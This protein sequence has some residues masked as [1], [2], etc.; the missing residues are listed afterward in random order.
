MDIGTAKPSREEQARVPHHLIDL[1]PPTEAYSAARF[2][3][4]A[5]DALKAILARGGRPLLVGGTLLYYR[6]LSEGLSDL[7]QASTQVRAEIDSEATRAGWP[8][9]HRELARIDPETAGRVDPE[10]R[11]RIQRAL[12]V[13]RITGEPLSRLRGRRA[14]DSGLRFRQFLLLPDDRKRLHDRIA[15]RLNG[16]FEAGL[17]DEVRALRERFALNAEL[18]AMR[19]VG[20][21]QV[22]SYLEGEI[23][24]PAMRETA[25]YA[26]RQLAKRQITWLRSLDGELLDPFADDLEARLD[27]AFADLAQ[28]YSAAQQSSGFV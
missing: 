9:L 4:D 12:E 3:Q 15:A 10:D 16:M 11:Q 20:Y 2:A 23:D 8:A 18:P 26:T 28:S 21:R 19:A 24:E 13:Y 17:V 27:A 1:V 22:W 25:L 7:P 6:A 14:A 5:R